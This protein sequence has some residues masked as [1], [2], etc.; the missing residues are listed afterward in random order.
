MT[1]SS[2]RPS[3]HVKARLTGLLPSNLT[4]HGRIPPVNGLGTR[5]PDIFVRRSR[6]GQHVRKLG[7]KTGRP[8]R[9]EAFYP[10]C[11]VTV[12]AALRP[13]NQGVGPL[14]EHISPHATRCRK[15]CPAGAKRLSVSLRLPPLFFPNEVV[16][17]GAAKRDTLAMKF[18]QSLLRHF[19]L[20][21]YVHHGIGC[22]VGGSNPRTCSA[23]RP[24]SPP[25]ALARPLT[26]CAHS[27]RK[28]VNADAGRPWR[29]LVV[30]QFWNSST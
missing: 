1:W 14:A 18:R 16:R 30:A 20:L 15:P 4:L 27:A 17:T 21:E 26:H 11:N 6:G 25:I 19:R 28:D 8:A 22:E 7:L 24:S 9:P 5:S 12:Y 13:T 29:S 2:V 23:F 10:S 3:H